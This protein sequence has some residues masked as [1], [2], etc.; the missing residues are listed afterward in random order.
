MNQTAKIV[1]AACH[2]PEQVA[3]RTPRQRVRSQALVTAAGL[4]LL[5]G[6]A[7]R[8][9][10]TAPAPAPD[11][12]APAPDTAT[13]APDTAAIRPA[14]PE[15]KNYRLVW[16]DEFDAA[17]WTDKSPKGEAKWFSRP[18]TADKYIGFQM[19]DNESLAIR[20]GILVNT[21]SF[22]P[23]ADVE[24]SR[25]AGPVGMEDAAGNALIGLETPGARIKGR[26]GMVWGNAGWAGMKFTPA[27]DVTVSRL[28]RYNI[29]GATGTYDVR[30]F[31]AA[32]GDDVAKAILNL[33]NQPDGWVYATLEGGG[34][35]T[36]RAGRSYYL[37][38][39]TLGWNGDYVVDEWHDGSS[40]V[41]A[42]DAIGIHGSAWGNWHAGS[43]F[44]IDNTKAGFTRQYGYWEAR[45]KMPAGGLGVWPS[46]CLYTVGK[47][48]TTLG[49][50]IDIF[51]YYGSAFAEN[52]DGGFGM[53]NHNWGDGPKE[54]S[55]DVWP[56]A[57]KPWENWHVYGFLAT[58]TNCAFYVDGERQ[59][60]F[61][62]PTSYLNSP[63]Y[64]TLEYCIGGWWP[65]TGLIA[66]S[67]LDVDWVRVWAPPEE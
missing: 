42:S 55:V 61:P 16:A 4:A 46:F 50:E 22:R 53:R 12:A 67:H 56:P 37:M 28:G 39:N 1:S 9:A 21:L 13:P 5:T 51:E 63:M 20:D 19:R 15:L 54:G 10:G 29:A 34:N 36:L 65:L 38:T 44:S 60:E 64:M 24:G 59:G 11:T 66:N 48:G 2:A 49:E 18:A 33:K 58:P 40:V 27:R 32:T 17:S 6:C 47:P 26:S 45:V 3:P 52:K 25:C 43:L 35:V 57:A 41:T 31:D 23:H 14:V 30:I 62:T 8:P 7:G